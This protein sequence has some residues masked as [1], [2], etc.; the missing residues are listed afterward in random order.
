MSSAEI[1]GSH[2][3]LEGIGAD[4]N[5]AQ[6][7]L[8]VLYNAD[9]AFRNIEDL[10]LLLDN[11]LGII[12]ECIPASR[13]FVFLIQRDTNQLV[14]YARRPAGVAA[15]DA[16]IVVSQT[17]IGGQTG[18]G[19]GRGG[20]HIVRGDGP[21]RRRRHGFG[22]RRLALRMDATGFTR[23]ALSTGWLCSRGGGWRRSRRRRGGSS[24]SRRRRWRLA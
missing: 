5:A 19:G 12:M 22:Q 16:E 24:S 9:A 18:K 21:Q 1:S 8:Q 2:E 14:P 15:D 20:G 4:P 23:V 3:I 6:R 11:L 13:G 7:A 17:I 10:S